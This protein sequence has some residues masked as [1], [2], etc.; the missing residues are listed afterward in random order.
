[1]DPITSRTEET[2]LTSIKPLFGRPYFTGTGKKGALIRL[3]QNLTGGDDDEWT[4]LLAATLRQERSGVKSRGAAA[5]F[6]IG[7]PRRFGSLALM[8]GPRIRYPCCVTACEDDRPQFSS[9]PCLQVLGLTF[10]NKSRLNWA[11]ISNYPRNLWI[12]LLLPYH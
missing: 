1:M 7:K 9:H 5:S 4:R 10:G 2:A 3:G 11:P 8:P 12:W 6:S